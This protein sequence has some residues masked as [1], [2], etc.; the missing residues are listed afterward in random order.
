[1]TTRVAAALVCG[2]V[3]LLSGGT[4]GAQ[5]PSAPQAVSAEQ[6]KAAIDKLGDLDYATRTNAARLVRRTTPAQA[7]PALLQ[8]AAEHADGYVRYRALVILTGFNDPRTRDA[9]R[10][11]LA[12]P[13]DRLRAVAYGYFERE[14]DASLLQPFVA[15]LDKEQ[16]E[17]VRPALVRALAALIAVDA[18]PAVLGAQQ[19]LVRDVSRGEDFF[20]SSVI[21]ALGDYRARYAYDAITEVAKAEGPL[22]DDAAL[23][24]GKIHDTRALETLAGLQRTAPRAAQPSIAAAICLLDVNCDA[25][26]GFLVETLKF[27]DKNAGFQELLRAA[28]AGLGAL[29][30][31][32]RQPAVDALLDVG[33][34]AKDD[35]TRAPVALAFATVALRRTPLALTVLE[36]YRDREGAIAL[37]ADG[38]DMLEEDL[39]KER[40]FAFVRRAYWD[41]ADGSPRRAL[42]QT[43]IARLD[44]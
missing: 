16:G 33:I 15:A 21:E 8:A 34:P 11:S 10:Q 31:A 32:G 22:Q 41:S 27:S 3:G 44:F 37:L 7:V 1:M 29:G 6:L 12:S 40:F 5:E 2:L 28:A 23:A 39:D 19:G 36:G 24:L 38:F 20:R 35:S 42:M 30:V 26:I 4:V 18:A 14:P 25:H 9:M 13:N 43:L 17:F